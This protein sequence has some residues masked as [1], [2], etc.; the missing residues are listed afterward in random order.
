M[1]AQ[2]G[3]AAVPSQKPA[4]AG[5]A[6]ARTDLVDLVER[7]DPSPRA[8]EAPRLVVSRGTAAGTEFVISAGKTV[9]GRHRD[10]DIVIDDAS[11]SR[12]HAELVV[13]GG[14]CILRDGG[15]LNGTYVNRSP[16]Q[17]AELADGDEIWIGTTRFTY[18]SG[19]ETIRRDPE[20]V[21]E[22]TTKA[23]SRPESDVVP[24]DV[25]KSRDAGGPDLP[26]PS[27]NTVSPA[28]LLTGPA[29]DR[30]FA[31]LRSRRVMANLELLRSSLAGLDLGSAD[32]A[33][34]TSFADQNDDTV[35]ALADL[36]VRA[37][38]AGPPLIVEHRA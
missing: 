12:Y 18:R 16:I 5:S 3:A 30:E 11:V 20:D 2:M 1:V 9:I 34:L 17:E 36:L 15:S 24:I 33:L 13:G 6:Q 31:D 14:R 37:R 35:H 38:S 21:T 23:V 26:A 7:A 28:F 32:H 10:C 29:A 8:A 19:D 4:R 22:W 27:W 25:L